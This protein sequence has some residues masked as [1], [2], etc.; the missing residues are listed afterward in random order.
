MN[1]SAEF[2]PFRRRVLRRRSVLHLGLMAGSALLAPP[3][4]A[5]RVPPSQ[6]GEG[7]TSG[8]EP[9]S[10]TTAGDPERVTV[11]AEPWRFMGWPANN[12][13]WWW[14]QGREMLVGF[15][16]GAWEDRPGH[17]IAAY[18]IK[19]LARSL[20]GGRSWRVETPEPF[21]GREEPPLYPSRG[22]RFDHPDLALRVAVDG[23][24][25]AR[26]R[27][28]RFFVSYDRGRRWQGPWRF[29][30]L[31]EAGR[32]A[33]LRMTSR[34]DYVVTGR[35]SALIVMSAQD[36][37]LGEFSDRLDKT[38]V[39]GTVDG[40]RSFQFLSWVVPWS[41]PYRAVMPSTVRLE[42]D[43]LV[44]ALRRRNPRD[45]EASDWV[46]A[47]RSADRGA[48]WSPL[49]PIG[50]TGTGNGNPPSLARLAD[51]R[52]ACA[53][54]N[55]S[56]GQMLVRVSLDQGRSW[57]EEIP[58]REIRFT[59]DFGYPRIVPNHLGELVVI[60]YLA[61]ETKPHSHIEA[62]ILRV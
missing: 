57:G 20:D 2:L 37:R 48:S 32:L 18:Q 30:G 61:T 25:E 56:L 21:V 33:G 55:R 45:A 51:G 44:T 7:P 46:D 31:A 62:A 11:A 36:P 54:G 47:Y 23:S 4:P 14:D 6:P 60:Y 13:C 35:D 53:Y 5:R 40:G 19:R 41:D 58:I 43:L 50:R 1:D 17:K 52:I 28:G 49:G 15:E 29:A 3:A 16:E 38:F 12:G 26:D 10:P 42:G 8:G 24:A 22:I 9:G 39:A 34:T 27:I 59:R